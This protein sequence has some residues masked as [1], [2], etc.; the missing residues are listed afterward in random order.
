MLSKKTSFY[1]DL[2]FLNSFTK[3]LKKNRIKKGS[4]SVEKNE[5]SFVLNKEK[6][7]IKIIKKERFDSHFLIEEL[8]LLTN[9]YLCVFL[10]EKINNLIY[11]IHDFPSKE[12]LNSLIINLKNHNIEETFNKKNIKNKLNN[13]IKNY[14]DDVIKEIILKSM[15][16]ACYSINNIGHFGLGF[17]Y[18]LHFTSPIRRYELNL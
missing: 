18:Y 3:K 15:S 5:L 4:I 12:K 16:K 11:R 13:I 17:D 9:N 10:K 7:P 6:Y 1:N 14:N 2:F 8:M